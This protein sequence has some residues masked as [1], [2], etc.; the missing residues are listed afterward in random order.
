MVINQKPDVLLL[1]M[2]DAI[3]AN[4]LIA[5]WKQ[6]MNFDGYHINESSEIKARFLILQLL[7][8]HFFPTS[9]TVFCI[10]RTAHRSGGDGISEVPNLTVLQGR[11]ALLCTP[12]MSGHVRGKAPHI[13]AVLWD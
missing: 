5:V 1:A 3:E 2:K 11:P 7:I 10:R 12:C 13:I 6:K 8:S 4:L 9:A